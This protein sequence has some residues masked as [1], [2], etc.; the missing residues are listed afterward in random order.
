MRRYMHMCI[1]IE[2]MWGCRGYGF[3]CETLRQLQLLR[4]T[5]GSSR[6]RNS[7]EGSPKQVEG[8]GFRV[9]GLDPKP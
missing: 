3:L 9:V 1:F 6:S 5:W 2:V 7:Q 4:K 8:L